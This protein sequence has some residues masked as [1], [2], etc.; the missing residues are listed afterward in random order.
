MAMEFV[1]GGTLA[2]LLKR[3]AGP[4]PERGAATYAL[5]VTLA[6]EHCHANFVIHRDIKPD[7]VLLT[8]QGWPLLCD[9]GVSAFCQ[10]V[11]RK[12]SCVGTKGYKAPE[13]ADGFE[14]HFS[15]RACLRAREQLCSCRPRCVRALRACRRN[16]RR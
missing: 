8:K 7:N 13:S 14:H 12:V 5:G 4:L 1:D 16:R 3:T 6:L 9:F 15:V 11:E 10:P 2:R